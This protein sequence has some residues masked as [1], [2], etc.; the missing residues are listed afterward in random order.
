MTH[1]MSTSL[2]H[3]NSRMDPNPDLSNGIGR[4]YGWCSRLNG[5]LRLR[6][7]CE[8]CERLGFSFFLS[9]F[10]FAIVIGWITF[11]SIIEILEFRFSFLSLFFFAFSPIC[12]VVGILIFACHIGLPARATCSNGFEATSLVTA[13]FV[14]RFSFSFSLLESE[15]PPRHLSRNERIVLLQYPK[16]LLIVG[17]HEPFQSFFVFH[18]VAFFTFILSLFQNVEGVTSVSSGWSDGRILD[19]CSGRDEEVAVLRFYH[20]V[21]IILKRDVSQ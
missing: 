21:G 14:C 5:G 19:G 1:G 15:I 2:V 9:A 16:S 8:G 20:L 10:S 18:P 13:L 7:L 11:V 12:L 4:L 3:S 17:W 6:L